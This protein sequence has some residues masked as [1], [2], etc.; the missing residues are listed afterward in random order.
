[1]LT[2]SIRLLLSAAAFFLA[3][4]LILDG[5]AGLIK[6]GKPCWGRLALAALCLTAGTALA[7]LAF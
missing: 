3:L 1:M 2:L 6:E 5:A 7:A 4:V